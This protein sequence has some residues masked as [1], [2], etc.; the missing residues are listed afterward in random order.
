MNEHDGEALIIGSG[1]PFPAVGQ[2]RRRGVR[3]TTAAAIALG[4]AIS[5]G[6]VAG[7][8]TSSTGS[9]TAASAVPAS[10]SQGN[11][12]PMGG[13]RPAAVGTVT[14]VGDGTFTLTAQDGTAVTVNV[15]TTTTY[16]DAGVTSATMANVTVGEHVAVFGTDT[17]NVVTATSVAVGEPP[18]GGKGGPEGTRGTPPKAPTSSSS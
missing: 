6:A 13:L 14:S 15:S 4:L 3:V 16:L 8:T 7:A 1:D 2:R 11:G 17:S 5:G 9:A 18:A 12:P 10:G